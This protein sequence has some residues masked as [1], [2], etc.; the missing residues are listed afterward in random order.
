MPQDIVPR[1]T[2]F[3]T[4]LISETN[5]LSL[6]DTLVLAQQSPQLQRDAELGYLV[7]EFHK[8]L[9]RFRLGGESIETLFAHPVSHAFEAFFRSF[10]IP[11]RDE[12]IHLT[13][14]LD[15]DFV[16]PRIAAL[17][18]GPHRELYESKIVAVYG[19][20]ALPIRSAADVDRM[21]RITEND[22]FERYLK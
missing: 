19:R 4:Q 18:E 11:F 9:G 8:R 12:H 1:L 13:G 3:V 17:L 22:R 2:R 5:G 14:S 6:E 21:I 15:A 7:R 20:D 10:P 16:Y